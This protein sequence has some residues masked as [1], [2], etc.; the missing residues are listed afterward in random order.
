MFK[1]QAEE[2]LRKYNSSEQTRKKTNKRLSEAIGKFQENRHILL[3][4]Q[5]LLE[6]E[7][8]S[9]NQERDRLHQDIERIAQETTRTI[10]RNK[11]LE[12]TLKG[13]EV[14]LLVATERLQNVEKELERGKKAR[15]S[16][17]SIDERLKAIAKNGST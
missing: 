7:K 3:E 11:E 1:A 15:E 17:A 4:K 13:K 16:L 2:A 9:L 12:G 6:S 10:Q 5:E 8:I 14:E